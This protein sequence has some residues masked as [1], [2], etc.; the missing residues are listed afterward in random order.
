MLL[1][2]Y[3]SYNTLALISVPFIIAG[4]WSYSFFYQPDT[5]LDYSLP[6]MND[7]FKWINQSAAVSYT[8]SILCISGGAF[9][10]NSIFNKYEYFDKFIFLP[11]LVYGLGMSS[12]KELLY[13][14]PIIISNLFVMMA[15]AQ[16]LQINRNEGAKAQVFN[17]GLLIGISSIFYITNGI[18]FPAALFVLTAIRSFNF[19]EM[20]L[21]IVGF[22]I[23]LLYILVY[24]Y[25]FAN[26]NF[27]DY[28]KEL[29]FEIS[30]KANWN[31]YEIVFY[32]GLALVSITSLFMLIPRYAKA[33]LRYKKIIN[34][35]II[36]SFW[37]LMWTIFNFIFLKETN[38]TAFL[39]I[40]M[41]FVLSF[42]FVY[43]KNQR[44]ASFIFNLGLI[45]LG[46][47]LFM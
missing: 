22:V 18:I 8:L 26:E 2:F 44:F 20:I 32:A 27:A 40:P 21:A 17:F 23:P 14:N 3:K 28:Y 30:F 12:N 39:T 33:G 7:F 31:I 19:K 45:A 5:H 29:A 37:I 24:A 46:L 9:L 43:L 13:F 15:F 4:I 34:I 36:F 41:T 25:L 6:F 47:M 35:F 16:L 1:R 42:Y 38:F 10:I 11:A